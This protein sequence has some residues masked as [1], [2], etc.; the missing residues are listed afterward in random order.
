ML[1]AKTTTLGRV[2][3]IEGEP[4]RMKAMDLC[5]QAACKLSWCCDACED[6]SAEPNTKDGVEAVCLY[7]PSW[8]MH[9]CFGD[10][11]GRPLVKR[12]FR[13][14]FSGVFDAKADQYVVEFANREMRRS[15]CG[16]RWEVG[17]SWAPA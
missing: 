1:R 7:A 12:T 8:A 16:R 10:H 2:M 5:L 3:A 13:K 17:K 9:I 4:T 15:R 6:A 14:L 11:H